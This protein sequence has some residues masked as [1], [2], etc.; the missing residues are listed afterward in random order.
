MNPQ[1]F[2]GPDLSLAHEFTSYPT[3]DYKRLPVQVIC[4]RFIKVQSRQ[5]SECI[6]YFVFRMHPD[7]FVICLN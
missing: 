4:T 2:K 1:P 5:L 7:G 6:P 3:E